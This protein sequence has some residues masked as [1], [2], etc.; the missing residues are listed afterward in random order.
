MDSAMLAV[1]SIGVGL[2]LSIL[3]ILLTGTKFA[4]NININTDK[5]PDNK[6]DVDNPDFKR[7]WD[8]AIVFMISN[9]HLTMYDLYRTHDVLDFDTHMQSFETRLNHLVT[10][11]EYRKETI[12]QYEEYTKGNI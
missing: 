12:K 3:L 5:T 6:N 10:N 1:V 2:I 4:P 9:I 8:E 7:G 11:N